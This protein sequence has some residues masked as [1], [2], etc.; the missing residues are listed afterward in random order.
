[1][2]VLQL[3]DQQFPLTGDTTRIGSGADADVALPGDAALGV[4]A[5]IETNEG[6]ALAIRRAVAIAR[7]A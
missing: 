6:E 3:D 5:V 2:A 7:F 4:Q 1:M